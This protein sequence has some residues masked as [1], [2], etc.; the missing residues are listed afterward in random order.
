MALCT[1]SLDYNTEGYTMIDNA[2]INHY[3]PYA[4]EN[5]LK[6]YLLGINLCQ[7]P[8]SEENNLDNMCISLDMTAEEVIKAFEYWE[9]RGLIGIISRSPLRIRFN[10]PRSAFTPNRKFNKNKY[11]DF[12]ENLQI[13]FPDRTLSSNELYQYLSLI[14]DNNIEADAVL[15]IAKYCV[16]LKGVSIRYPYITAV[17]KN[18]IEEGCHTVMDVEERLKE[19]EAA[20]ENIRAIFKALK[21]TSKPDIE[22]R[23]HYLKWTKNWGYDDEAILL[24]AKSVKRGGMQKLDSVLDDYFK[25]GI[26]TSQDIKEYSKHRKTMFDTAIEINRVLG[27]FYQSL[28]HI[29]ETY[30][31]D[32][33]NKGFER[34]GLLQIAKYCFVNSVRQLEGMNKK[35][36]ELYELGIVSEA[37]INAHIMGLMKNDGIISNIIAATGS[38]RNVTENDRKFY[39]TWSITWRFSDDEILEAARIAEGRAYAFTYINK[40]LSNWKEERISGSSDKPITVNIKLDKEYRIAEIR[41]ALKEDDKYRGL[42]NERKK[43][44]LEISNYLSRAEGVPITL[45]TQYKTLLKQIDKRII[46]LGYSPEDIKRN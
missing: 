10:S 9:A 37:S 36:L 30:I 43:L 32:W 35:V 5:A 29:V 19:S 8:A 44:A 21:K 15:L 16:D 38:M 18:W 31:L 17:A 34:T 13:L 11:S 12:I 39:K 42:D 22:D 14:E 6:V 41:S 4:D 3:L 25:Q 46:K 27:L 23:Q 28:D 7:N 26:F 45:D 33:F 20:S 2:F 24:A 40:V 1:F